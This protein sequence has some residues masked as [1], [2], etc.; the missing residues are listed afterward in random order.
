METLRDGHRRPPGYGRGTALKTTTS[1]C[2]VCLLRI[3]AQVRSRDGQVWMDKECPEHGPFSAQLASQTAHYY[4]HDS[5]LDAVGGCCGPGQHCG[6]QVANHSC[7]MLIEITQRCNLTCPTCYADSSPERHETMELAR[8]RALVDELLEKGKGDADLIQLSGGEPTIHPDLMDMIGYALTRGI[9]RVYINTNGIRLAH[10][11]FA[12][13]LASFGDRVSV[14]LQFD[15]LKR[16]TLRLLRGRE[17]LVDT[18]LRALSLCEELGLPAVPVMTLTRGVNDDELGAFLDTALRHPRAVQKVMIQPAMY[19]GRYENPR[20]VER[21]TVGDVARLVHEQTE[22]LWVDEDF[23]PIPCSD[24]NCFSMA[25]ALRTPDGLL[26]VSRYFPRYPTW[27]EPG[28]MEMIRGV[29]DT[30]DDPDGL[31]AA[32]QWAVS[33]G[34][35]D[36]LDED[37]VDRLLDEVTAWQ[38][39]RTDPGAE[40]YA[41]LFAI[42]VKPFMD[43]YTY[44]QDRIDKCCVHIIS[45]SG[46][47]VSFCEYNAVNRPTGR[48]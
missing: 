31:Q 43:A 7:N 26:P 14:Y 1:L 19:S 13:E 23:G 2:P 48:G 34:A 24:P 37:T 36:R 33:N 10:R 15:G 46:T 25:V 39:A 30:F 44:D 38:A 40:R 28:T 12:E 27:S 9:K 22:G 11:A 32:L 42:G 8:F 47:P 16:R 3:S 41:G 17:E 4:R 35:L 5:R 29:A 45:Q 20:L 6:D 18:K 21:I